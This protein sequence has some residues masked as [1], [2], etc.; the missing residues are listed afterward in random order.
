M[1]PQ[2]DI[3]VTKH[4]HR[5][6]SSD[7]PKTR[8]NVRL[9]TNTKSGLRFAIVSE[10]GVTGLFKQLHILKEIEIGD[11]SFDD[12]VYVLGD[13]PALKDLVAESPAFRR[14][15]EWVATHKYK[16]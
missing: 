14:L 12:L 2:F 11:K 7:D 5:S 4:P 6:Q 16:I 13:E 1:N 8:A 10:N 3:R 15:C 9:L